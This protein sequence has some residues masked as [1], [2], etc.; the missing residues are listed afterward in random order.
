MCLTTGNA[1]IRVAEKDIYVYKE[2]RSVTA[3][4][5]TPEFY[6]VTE[7]R[8]GVPTDKIALN[9]KPTWD[10][11]FKVEKGYH[12]YNSPRKATNTVFKIPKGTQ[13]ISGWYNGSMFIRNRVSASIEYVGPKK[14][15]FLQRLFMKLF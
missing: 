1:K 12:S 7:Y 11:K 4:S 10:G 3:E 14:F 15:S 9:P 6:I 2:C 8:T 5:C 13:Y